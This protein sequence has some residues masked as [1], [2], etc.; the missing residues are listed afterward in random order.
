MSNISTVRR[1]LVLGA[2]SLLAAG[3][4][5]QTAASFP[6]KPITIVVPYPAGT[7]GDI[8]VRTLG[9]E[10]SQ[11]LKQPIIVDNRPG[12]GEV[13]GAN[14]LH[15]SPANGYTLMSTLIPNMISSAIQAK[16]PY[17]SIA[18]FTVVAKMASLSGALAVGP[19]IPA[20]NVKELVALLKAQPDRMSYA[21]AGL[22][23]ANHMGAA[24]FSKLTDT[25]GIHVPFR[26]I[27]QVVLE[28]SSGRVDYAFLPVSVA[29][30]FGKEG[31]VKVLG[32]QLLQ[33]YADQPTMPTLDEQGVKGYDSPITFLLIGPKGMP[34]PIVD[35]LNQAIN[36]AMATESYATKMRAIGGVVIPKAM[37]SAE[38]TTLAVQ[39]ETRW[40][41]LVKEMNIVLE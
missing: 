13:I 27:Q 31:K 14:F 22:G 2:A 41:A 37:S 8:M 11:S 28:L 32:G 10:I 1:A 40:R 16:L 21:S 29:A 4:G 3:A 17:K 35:K 6:D 24:L 26:S 20:A 18:D 34:A 25:R 38:A 12:A 15:S 36:T 39:E 23:S 30:Q 7:L 19:Q 9:V 5:A 33:R